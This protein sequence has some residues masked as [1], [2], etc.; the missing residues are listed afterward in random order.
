MDDQHNTTNGVQASVKWCP[1]CRSA[2]VVGIEQDVCPT[3]NGTGRVPAGVTVASEQ[4]FPAHPP[5]D[6]TP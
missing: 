4:A 2:G 5:M 3:C 1:E 6:P